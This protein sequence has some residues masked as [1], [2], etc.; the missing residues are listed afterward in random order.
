M[1]GIRSLVNIAL[2]SETLQ[3]SGKTTEPA[4]GRHGFDYRWEFRYFLNTTLEEQSLLQ[5]YPSLQ[6]IL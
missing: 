3:S 2:L 5:I 4:I 6:P 1:V